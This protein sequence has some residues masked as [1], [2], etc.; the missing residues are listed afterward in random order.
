MKV[1]E[2][3]KSESKTYY[4][5]SRR[6]ATQ[7]GGGPS[8]VKIDPIL[9]QVCNI[10]GR[11]CTGIVGVSDSDADLIIHEMKTMPKVKCNDESETSAIEIEVIEINNEIDNSARGGV[12]EQ[13]LLNAAEDP[14]VAIHK[15][16]LWSRRRP[17]QSQPNERTEAIAML[18]DSFKDINKKKE[19]VEDLK[20]QL[21]EMEIEFK[22]KL[23]ELQLQ[24][25]AKEVEIKTEI[26]LQIKGTSLFLFSI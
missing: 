4:S 3:M 26:L 6:N 19:N 20:R 5:L 24:A 25:A 13:P 15:T 16:P 2:K 18:G 8:V 23:Y 10:M 21:C 11:G 1:W 17:Q 22:R 7:T 9:E 14:C 12:P